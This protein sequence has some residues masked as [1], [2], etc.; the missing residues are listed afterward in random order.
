MAPTG[1]AVLCQKP[2]A[3]EIEIHCE[4]RALA[5]RAERM[6][7]GVGFGRTTPKL[8]GSVHVAT[9]QFPVCPFLRRYR[10]N[11]RPLASPYELNPSLVRIV[12]GLE[13]FA[14]LSRFQ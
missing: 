8:R 1:T 7:K 9:G 12:P 14:P 3:P 4:L 6:P 5:R 2:E 13:F 10:N 11:K